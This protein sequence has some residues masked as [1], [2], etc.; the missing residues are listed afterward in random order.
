MRVCWV[1]SQSG[2]SYASRILHRSEAQHR[3]QGGAYGLRVHCADEAELGPWRNQPINDHP[4][5]Q[6]VERDPAQRA[7][8][9][10]ACS[11]L[12]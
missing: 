8:A 10:L 5:H 3:A 11:K 1:S 7:Q 9:T 12:F 6:P 4:H 2:A